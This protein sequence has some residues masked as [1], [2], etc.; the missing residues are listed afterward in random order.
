ML[1]FWKRMDFYWQRCTT[2]SSFFFLHIV[3]IAY[4][5]DLC[6]IGCPRLIKL[7]SEFHVYHFFLISPMHY[8]FLYLFKS[9]RVP[10]VHHPAL[11]SQRAHI[12]AVLAHN[13]APSTV[14]TSHYCF[15]R[16]KSWASGFPEVTY[17]PAQEEHVGSHRGS[18]YSL[19]RTSLR[20]R[21]LVNPDW[22]LRIRNKSVNFDESV[23]PSFN[24]NSLET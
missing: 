14:K 21:F 17:F 20:F 6:V 8:F 19:L 1:I 4:T 15:K 3:V 22:L 12:P 24:L 7:Q 10:R 11:E 23:I 13:K 9:S 5:Q 16:W 18:F 2:F